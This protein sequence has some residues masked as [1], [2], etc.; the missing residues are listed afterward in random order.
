[1]LMKQLIFRRYF[2]LFSGTRGKRHLLNV[3]KQAR[4]SQ[5]TVRL[6]TSRELEK[7]KHSSI[8]NSRSSVS[9]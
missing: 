6:P 8:V 1:M 3:S 7:K 2:L 9:K 4:H 5:I